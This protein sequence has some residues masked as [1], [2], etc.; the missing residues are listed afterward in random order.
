MAGRA[1]L[2]GHAHRKRRQAA[3]AASGGVCVL[4]GKPIDLTLSGRHPDGPTLEHLIPV[5]RGGSPDDPM[6]L[7]VSHQRCNSAKGKKLLSEMP[8]RDRT[9]RDWT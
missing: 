6:N 2:R 5:D 1:D 7:G 4:C 3:I 8:K 9:S